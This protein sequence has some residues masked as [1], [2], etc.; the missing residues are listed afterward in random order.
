MLENFQ[1][2]HDFIL[3]KVIKDENALEYKG[4]YL[5]TDH[6]NFIFRE[7]KKTP[8]KSGQFVTF[9][10]RDDERSPIRP[11]DYRDSFDF[12]MIYVQSQDSSGHFIFPKDILLKKNI[13]SKEK[14]GGKRA[15]RV[16]PPWD[17]ATSAQAKKTQAWQVEYF[18]PLHP[19]F[20]PPHLDSKPL[21]P[22]NEK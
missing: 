1:T 11:F 13:I 12:F 18:S 9:W 21:R 4:Y 22:E 16:Y 19:T 20:C 17:M 15:L 8:K 7:G 10:Q 5:F 6:F 3:T 2:P 14:I